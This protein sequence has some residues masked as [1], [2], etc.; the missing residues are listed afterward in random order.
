VVLVSNIAADISFFLGVWKA[1]GVVVPIHRSVPKAAR[2]ALMARIKNRFVIKYKVEVILKDQPPFR[3]LLEG[4]GTIIFTS[5]STGDPKGVVL[6]SL[7]AS[8][9]LEMIRSMTTGERAKML[10]LDCRSL[11]ALVNGLHGLLS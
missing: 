2:T 7:K 1:R 6:S 9:K 3:P 11:S 10:S 4:A 8:R 5:G